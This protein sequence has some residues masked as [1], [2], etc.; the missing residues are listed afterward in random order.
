MT[1]GPVK[2][3][4]SPCVK[5]CFVDPAEG[6]CV[7]CFRTLEELARWTAYSDAERAAIGLDLPGRAEA[8]R[9]QRE[10]RA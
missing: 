10:A 5:V 9:A 7:G 4:W 3:I 2:A 8:Y 1:A 6:V